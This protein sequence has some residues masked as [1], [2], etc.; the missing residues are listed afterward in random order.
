ME[1]LF[2]ITLTF[3]ALCGVLYLA[4]DGWRVFFC[5]ELKES[6]FTV[7]ADG[8]AFEDEKEL[9]RALLE[10]SVFLSRP[11]AKYLVREVVITNV[12]PSKVLEATENFDVPLVCRT[13]EEVIR[14]F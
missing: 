4:R 10:L 2:L 7:L 3:F 14:R 12:A 13:A 11:E 8:R 9:S 6:Y 1:T 5:R